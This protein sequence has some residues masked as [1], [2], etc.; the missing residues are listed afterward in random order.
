MVENPY[1]CECCGGEVKPVEDQPGMGKCAYCRRLQPIPQLKNRDWDE[2]FRRAEEC[3]KRNEFS[4]AL[5]ILKGL[6]NDQPNNAELNWY[7]ALCTYGIEY[8]KD[9][10]ED[11]YK[12]TI[13]R[14]SVKP[15]KDCMYYR[16]AVKNSSGEMLKYYKDEGNK[17]SE[18]LEEV[19]KQV[20]NEKPFDVFI[21]FKNKIKD[22]N[23][24]E[25][26]ETQDTAYAYEIY[27]VLT[28]RNE[29]KVF[30]SPET[31]GK[32]SVQEY[33]PIIYRALESSKIMIL[34]GSRREYLESAWVKNEWTRYVEMEDEDKRQRK[35]P[36]D[37]NLCPAVFNGLP[38]EILPEVLYKKYARTQR[39]DTTSA[40]WPEKLKASIR[41][42]MSKFAPP[43]PVA[44]PSQSDGSDLTAIKEDQYNE[45]C[46][47]A[48]IAQK[49]V[50]ERAVNNYKRAAEMLKKLGSFK[51]SRELAK[52]YERAANDAQME[53]RYQETLEKES[54]IPHGNYTEMSRQYKL[55]A[56]EMYDIGDYR[57]AKESAEKYDRLSVEYAEKAEEEERKRIEHEKEINYD[58]AKRLMS[59][60]AAKEKIGEDSLSLYYGAVSA[61]ENAG[62]FR[63]SVSLLDVCNGKI[64]QI[65]KNGS[66][67]RTIIA[68]AINLLLIGFILLPPTAKLLQ[69]ALGHFDILSQFQL[70]AAVTFVCG[71]VHGCICRKAKLRWLLIMVFIAGLLVLP[72]KSFLNNPQSV[73]GR[74][75]KDNCVLLVPDG[76]HS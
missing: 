36:R 10:Y 50:G 65:E 74:T 54:Y 67:V 20:E 41:D 8:T 3:R 17:I 30:F 25:T 76:G 4:D 18:Y 9:E 73:P 32:K 31:L 68:A 57:E 71:I 59:E 33:E 28:E 15:F 53:M 35:S 66:W 56:S 60:A 7:A 34:V 64:S 72:L 62:D 27:N 37:H 55:L 2:K 63:D 5:E 51:D 44:V 11:E 29:F 21:S 49:Q 19:E 70:I 69:S 40:S 43:A 52:K 26:A 1:I 23:G 48:E 58:N 13:H 16:E 47:K 22:E 24:K 42:I 39:I 38:E 45:A 46:Q 6:L 61:L 75:R 14:Y 12:P